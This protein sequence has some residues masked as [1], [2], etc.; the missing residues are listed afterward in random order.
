VFNNRR[1]ID[2]PYIAATTIAGKDHVFVGDNDYNFKPGQAA[3]DRSL[4]SPHS[5]FTPFSV[6]SRN[7]PG[8][9]SEV[10]PALTANG[11]VVYAAFNRINS[12]SNECSESWHAGTRT[13]DVVVVRDDNGGASI[14]PFSS[15][16]DPTDN[17]IG[18]LVVNR[19]FAWDKC[20]GGDRLGGDLAIAVHPGDQNKVYLVW[21]DWVNG[22]ASLHLKYSTNGGQD[23]SENNK[24]IPDAKNPGLAVNTEGIVGFLYQQVEK[25]SE[26]YVWKTKLERMSDDFKTS[27]QPLTFATFPT[28]APLY[29]SCC[30]EILLGDYLHLM[31]VRNDFYGI[32]SSDNTP[33]R[34]H[35]PWDVK[36]R[37]RHDFKSKN[38]LGLDA[39]P[40]DPSIDPFCFKVTEQ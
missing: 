28:S 29:Q 34:L 25:T 12:A 39:K 8:D 38:L 40:V 16:V 30:G 31:S 19:T 13:S 2:Q 22:H 17:K 14:P 11:N 37:R 24:N 26:G 36:F 15:L 9:S 7:G 33:D 23:W 6:E 21:S 35:F 20:L 5:S 1:D 32:F 27:L 4:D 18:R 3:L 10:R